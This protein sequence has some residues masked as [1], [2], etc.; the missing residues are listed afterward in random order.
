MSTFTNCADE[1]ICATLSGSDGVVVNVVTGTPDKIVVSANNIPNSALQTGGQ[2]KINESVFTLG[3]TGSLDVGFAFKNITDGTNT[4]VADGANDTLKLTGSNGVVITVTND[5]STD[6]DRA[7]ISLSGGPNGALQNSSITINGDPVNLGG[8]ITI[9]T[10]TAGVTDITGTPNQISA[11]ADYIN[12][13]AGSVQLALPQDIDTT[14]IVTF[15]SVIV[16]DT[17][18]GGLAGKLKKLNT[19]Y[20]WGKMNIKTLTYLNGYNMFNDNSPVIVSCGSS[21]FGVLQDGFLRI[22][23]VDADNALTFD[24]TCSQLMIQTSSSINSN[25]LYSAVQIKSTRDYP[26]SY[27]FNFIVLD[28]LNGGPINLASLELN[29]YANFTLMVNYP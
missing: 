14:S 10:G 27:S 3:Q 8:S 9:D 25:Y 29:T 26:K 18:D 1:L 21:S 23:V 24:N 2:L 16:T 22:T 11:N 6:G 5:H 28:A 15:E 12:S 4:A 13:Q 19:P 20:A 7:L 17:S